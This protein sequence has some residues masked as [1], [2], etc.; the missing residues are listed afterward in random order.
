MPRESCRR[1]VGVSTDVRVALIWAMSENRVIGRAGSLPWRLPDEM[2]YFKRTTM[3]KPVIMGRRTWLG[4]ALPG[5]LNVI[6]S[7]AGA[8]DV[9]AG[10]VVVDSLTRALSVATERAAEDGVIEVMVIGGAQLYG[11]ALPL[12]DRLYMTVVHAD[13]AGDVFFPEFGLAD[14]VEV[15]CEVHAAD[16]RHAH[17]F[18][19]YVLDRR[20]GVPLQV[21]SGTHVET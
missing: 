15:R 8:T 14:F 3:G 7:R 16:A 19:M 20:S 21:S 18:T 1:A 6:V 12:A 2:A 13:L 9:P 11:H 4:R 17:A 5:R 10:V